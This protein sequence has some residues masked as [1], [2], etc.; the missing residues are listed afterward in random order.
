MQV[1]ERLSVSKQGRG[2]IKKVFN[3][4]ILKSV[5]NET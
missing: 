1:R 2:F 3:M 4:G 5:E